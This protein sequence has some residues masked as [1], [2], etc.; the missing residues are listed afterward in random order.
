MWSNST[1]DASI[2]T[3]RSPRGTTANGVRGVTVTVIVCGSRPPHVDRRH[4]RQRRHD[5]AP[6]EGSVHGGHVVGGGDTRGLA[7]RLLGDPPRSVDDDVL[8]KRQ[9][10]RPS[11]P[12]D[13]SPATTVP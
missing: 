7:D 13:R 10:R 5:V 12:P 1:P 8:D 6:H 11:D 2:T 3:Y 9:R 4:R